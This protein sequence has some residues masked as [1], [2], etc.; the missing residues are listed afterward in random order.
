MNLQQIKYLHNLRKLQRH[1]G[2]DFPIGFFACEQA[3]RLVWEGLEEDWRRPD[4]QGGWEPTDFDP[5]KAAD[6]WA[7][8]HSWVPGHFQPYKHARYYYNKYNTKWYMIFLGDIDL[9]ISYAPV[10][11]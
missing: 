8:M 10:R 5:I 1:L 7:A 11:V 4:S 3:Q 9:G 2:W 6:G